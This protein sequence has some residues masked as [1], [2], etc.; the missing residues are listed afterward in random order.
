MIIRRLIRSNGT[1]LE[2]DGPITLREVRELIGAAGLD[3]VSLHHLGRPLHVMCCDDMGYDCEMVELSPG[4]FEMRP[5]SARKP[6]NEEATRLYLANCVP[7]TTH[8]I[9]GDVVVIP[10]ED[11]A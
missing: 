5:R 1:G 9:V 7:G 4:H 8:R 2:L 3:F 6:V 10:D 11:F